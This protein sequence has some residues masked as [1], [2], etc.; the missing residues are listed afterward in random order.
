[1]TEKEK[2]TTRKK[3]KGSEVRRRK[4]YSSKIEVSGWQPETSSMAWEKRKRGKNN[5]GE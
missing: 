5:K 1:V 2:E 4:R 3:V